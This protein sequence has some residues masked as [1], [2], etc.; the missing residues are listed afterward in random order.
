MGAFNIFK[1]LCGCIERQ[2]VVCKAAGLGIPI[3]MSLNRDR[4]APLL[5]SNDLYRYTQSFTSTP[6][7]TTQAESSAQHSASRSNARDGPGLRF[8]VLQSMRQWS[9]HPTSEQGVASSRL[10]SGLRGG[11]PLAAGGDG[12]RLYR[13]AA[14][15]RRRKPSSSGG[16]GGSCR[17]PAAAQRRQPCMA[18]MC[19]LAFDR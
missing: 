8:R 19:S 13:L 16:G 7:C 1:L 18:D 14:A 3:F 17:C 10:P 5:P 15:G 4:Q 11:A 2:K 6:A 9:S 12:D